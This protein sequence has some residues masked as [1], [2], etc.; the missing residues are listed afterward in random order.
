MACCWGI[1]WSPRL[2][3][4]DGPT[5]SL[6]PGGGSPLSR[7]SV[8]PSPTLPLVSLVLGGL[9]PASLMLPSGV[10]ARAG[11]ITVL[12]WSGICMH[13][14]RCLPPSIPRFS[15]C[16]RCNYRRPGASVSRN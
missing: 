10:A 14:P 6:P 1:D 11:A 12:S 4:P 7:V 15:A 8:F 13:R 5:P 3:H 16:P 9:V 2:R